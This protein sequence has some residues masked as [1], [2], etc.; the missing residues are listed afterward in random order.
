MKPSSARC[1]KTWSA[2]L[3][4]VGSSG[5]FL[6][7]QSRLSFVLH[8]SKSYLR[9]DLSLPHHRKPLHLYHPFLLRRRNNLLATGSAWLRRCA[10]VRPTLV[11]AP[12]T[13]NMIRMLDSI[14][15]RRSL[16]LAVTRG[17]PPLQR[18][19]R[20][21]LRGNPPELCGP[22]C[23]DRLPLAIASSKSSRPQKKF[24][25]SNDSGTASLP[26]PVRRL[27]LE[28]D[29]SIGSQR[30]SIDEAIHHQR[31]AF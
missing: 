23:S 16:L 30:G 19:R 7:V 6:F 14:R 22:N 1:A 9:H 12:M 11:S 26:G 13:R 5:L 31:A 20:W 21:L 8:Q 18:L 28:R 2:G 17:P 4:F 3:S 25:A 29:P 15:G 27:C 24:N 10:T